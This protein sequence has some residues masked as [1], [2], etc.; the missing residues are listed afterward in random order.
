MW[1]LH[2]NSLIVSPASQFD[3]GNIPHARITNVNVGLIDIVF[4]QSYLDMVIDIN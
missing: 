4:S 3:L 1:N 2:L